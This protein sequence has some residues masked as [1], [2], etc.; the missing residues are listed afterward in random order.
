MQTVRGKKIEVLFSAS[1]IALRNL[2]LAKELPGAT[3]MTF[4]SYRS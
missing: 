1:T 4:W 2:E 3:I